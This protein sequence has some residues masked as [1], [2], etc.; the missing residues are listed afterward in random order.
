MGIC[1]AFNRLMNFHVVRSTKAVTFSPSV[2]LGDPAY[3]HQREPWHVKNHA[4]YPDA[5]YYLNNIQKYYFRHPDLRH[6]RHEQFNRGRPGFAA[7]ARVVLN[8][9][10]PFRATSNKK[11]SICTA[12]RAGEAICTSQGNTSPAK[13]PSRKRKALLTTLHIATR[14]PLQFIFTL[15]K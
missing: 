14:L 12:S 3:R 6:L 9:S 11:H 10:S 8:C 13:I 2:F 4:D 15:S 1:M 7:L 5:N